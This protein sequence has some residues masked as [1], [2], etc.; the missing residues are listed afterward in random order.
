MNR[1]EKIK[2]HILS[3]FDQDGI[4]RENTNDGVMRFIN[5]GTTYEFT[6]LAVF[7]EKLNQ[8]H[9]NKYCI[10]AFHQT[11][12]PRKIKSLFV[13]FLFGDEVYEL[14]FKNKDEKLHI[15]FYE[16]N[17]FLEMYHLPKHCNSVEFKEFFDQI[18][19]KVIAEVKELRLL[20]LFDENCV[21]LS[22]ALEEIWEEIA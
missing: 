11:V 22:N 7:S 16:E 17:D 20:Y 4:T 13:N 6:F 15:S 12:H 8:I 10:T 19:Q 9:Q 2:S 3:R 5:Q 1:E 18:L 21:K 14:K